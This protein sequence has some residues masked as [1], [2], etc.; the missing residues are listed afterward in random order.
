M[1]VYVIDIIDAVPNKSKWSSSKVNIANPQ[2]FSKAL[3]TF[4][5]GQNDLSYGF[6]Y[7]HEAQV[8]AS[9]PLIIDN[10]TQA[11]HVCS[12]FLFFRRAHTHSINFSQ[13]VFN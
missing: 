9:I 7:T 8:R 6:Q 3:Y 11:I 12:F 2:D 13:R 10:F 1:S 5:I 4:D